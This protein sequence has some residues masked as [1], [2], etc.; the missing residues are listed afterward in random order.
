M[1]AEKLLA[2]LSGEKNFQILRV[3]QQ[4][5]QDEI[6]ENHNKKTRLGIVLDKKTYGKPECGNPEK[7]KQYPS[8]KPDP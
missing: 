2:W 7:K 4:Q 6:E 1:N 8:H 5:N 3:N